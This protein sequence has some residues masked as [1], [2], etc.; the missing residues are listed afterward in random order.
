MRFERIILVNEWMTEPVDEIAA[1]KWTSTRAREWTSARAN[2][3][4]TQP[5]ETK[6]K[7]FLFFDNL[8]WQI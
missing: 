5:S 2:D 3:W 7:W 6:E 1:G 8:L 4:L